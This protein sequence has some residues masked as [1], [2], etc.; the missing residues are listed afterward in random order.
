MAWTAEDIPDQT[1]R[2]I[3]VTGA[4]SGIGLETTRELARNGATVV[5]ACRNL[6]RA[7]D[8]AADVRE[9]IADE[10]PSGSADGS[11]GGPVDLEIERLDLASLDSIQAFADR[12][13]D[14]ATGSAKIDVLINNAGTMA[15]PRRETEDGFE[16]QFG[17]NH[18]GHF[19]L[20]GFLLESIADDG[21]IVT[22]SSEM[23]RRGSIAFEDL[24]GE[25]RYDKWAAYRQ[26][27]L[28]N[29]CFASELDRRL[30]AAGSTITSVAVHPGYADT[31]LQAR[32]PKR[33]GSRVGLAAVRVANA[34]FAQSAAMGALPTLYAATAPDVDG[35]AYYGPRDFLRRRGPPEQ[36]R[37]SD[38]SYDRDLARR[39]WEV[40]ERETG[41][42]FELPAVETDS[43]D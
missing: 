9:S 30:D 35:G 8:A 39:L 16:T 14:G 27:K 24:H 10:S 31:P 43:V 20:T 17:V 32:G 42:R 28:A 3:V 2:R 12:V 33:T 37:S 23:H 22:V 40:S 34:L 4:N 26:S 29:V 11:V 1:G 36:Q 21:R 13:S 38:T 25:T 5:M 41:V 7:E 15:I 18:L 19:A 6:E